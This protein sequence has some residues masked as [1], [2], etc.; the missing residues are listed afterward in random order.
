MISLLTPAPVRSLSWH[1]MS[2]IVKWRKVAG[3]DERKEA[4][5]LAW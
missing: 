1:P 2:R 4:H 3:H 5:R